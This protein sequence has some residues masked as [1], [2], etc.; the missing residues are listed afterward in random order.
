MK[1]N[2]VQEGQQLSR[3]NFVCLGGAAAAGVTVLSPSLARGEEG[4][5]AVGTWPWPEFGLDPSAVAGGD[6][7]GLAGCATT[8]FGL[9]LNGLVAALGPD[10]PWAKIPPQLASAFNGGGPYGSD[11]GALQGGQFLMTLVGAPKALK[12]EF[13]KWYCEFE[14]PTTE[15]DH[16]YAFDGTVQTVAGSPLCHESRSIW[17]GV[18]LREVYPIT[19]VYDN[20]RC[21]KLPRDCTKKAIEL[22]N[23]FK[24]NG[25]A[26]MWYP[27]STFQGCYDCHT[28]LYA[29]K[30]PGGI[31]SG[32]EDCTRCHEV[33]RRHPREYR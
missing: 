26:G 29:D 20:T 14:F 32:K 23:D 2:G 8:T 15:W 25:Y 6:S 7:T 4:L 24:L 3:R 18:F 5:P 11:C 16:L 27:D 33:P 10:S 22:V 31:H 13:Y 28:D 19:G 1:K 21:Q 17:E 12:Q 30:L 9:I